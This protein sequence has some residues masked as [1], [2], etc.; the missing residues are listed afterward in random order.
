MRLWDKLIP[1]SGLELVL[2]D[3]NKAGEAVVPPSPPPKQDPKRSKTT[4]QPEKT[5]N[6][7]GNRNQGGLKNKDARAAASPAKDRRA[8]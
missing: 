2:V 7:G 4:Q 5:A 8:Q 3:K 6:T 1:L